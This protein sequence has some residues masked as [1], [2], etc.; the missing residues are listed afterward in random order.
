[1]NATKPKIFGLILAGGYSR[2][3]G[4]DKA[5]LEFHGA[6]QIEHIY[7]LLQKYCSKVFLSKRADQKEHKSI[8]SINDSNEFCEQGPLGG[9]LSAMKKYPDA[10]WL[11]VACDLPFITGETIETL[12]LNRDPQKQATAF[13]STHDALPEPLCAIWEKHAYASFLR[14]FHEGIHCPRKILIKSD[15]HL[16]KQNNPHWLDNVNTLQEYNQVKNTKAL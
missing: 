1:M 13:I 10:D 8:A 9:I 16:L 5:L 3:M 6:P 12:L 4:Q 7:G 11:V 15:T 2:R 14:L